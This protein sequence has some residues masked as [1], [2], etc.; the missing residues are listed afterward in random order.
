MQDKH[1]YSAYFMLFT[2]IRRKMTK[3]GLKTKTFI[4][5]QKKFS[6]QI[7]TKKISDSFNL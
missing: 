7:F 6:N 3:N 2:Y 4:V 5:R 1:L